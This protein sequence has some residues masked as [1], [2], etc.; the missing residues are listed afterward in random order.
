MLEIMDVYKRFNLDAGF[1]AKVGRFVYAVNGV[2][3]T[4]GENETYGLVGESGCGKTTLA[5][6]V[7]RM[8]TFDSGEIRYRDKAGVMRTFTAIGKDESKELRDR[9]KYIFQDPARSLNPRMNIL[10]I[11]VEGYRYSS[12]WPGREKAEEEASSI[13]SDVG[14]AQDDLNRRPQDFSGGQRQRISIARALISKPEFLICDEIVS[15]LDVSIQSQILSLLLRL[16]ETYGFHMLFIAHDLAVVTYICDRVGV[17]YGGMIMEE[18]TSMELLRNPLH[19]YTG[20]LYSAIPRI[21]SVFTRGKPDDE[22]SEAYDP[23][24]EPRGCPF[25]PRCH[26]RK[27]ACAD[28]KPRLLEVEKGHFVACHDF[29]GKERKPV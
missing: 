29:H 22:E 4:I 16:K 15:A 5:R 27:A 24:I 1:F 21:D 26:V 12:S 18:A 23:T 19:P 28:V 7:I 2:S 3:L 25:C 20:H 6:L 10:D 14:L 17:M 13:L 11:L 8:Y 9:I